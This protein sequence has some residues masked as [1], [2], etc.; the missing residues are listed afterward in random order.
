MFVQYCENIEYNELMDL[1]R[2]K[3]TIK[4]HQYL[5]LKKRFNQ[6]R[7]KVKEVSS[8]FKNKKFTDANYEVYFIEFIRN[9]FPLKFDILFRRMSPIK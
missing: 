4:K 9:A 8:N 6:L 2:G 7:I 3:T 1:L 5:E